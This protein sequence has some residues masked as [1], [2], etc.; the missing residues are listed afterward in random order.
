MHA[1]FSKAEIFAVW[2]YFSV[3]QASVKIMNE[4]VKTLPAVSA[5]EQKKGADDG[6]DKK[7]QGHQ[8]RDILFPGYGSQN[9][10]ELDIP[11]SHHP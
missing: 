5:G 1:F 4:D 2:R 11:R 10:Q 6:A 3:F 8:A 7:R 9:A